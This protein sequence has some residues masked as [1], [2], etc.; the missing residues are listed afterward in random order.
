[1]TANP[2]TTTPS[3]TTL[4]SSST[5]LA[6]ALKEATAQAHTTAEHSRFM[7]RLMAGELDTDH[8]IALTEQLHYLYTALEEAIAR[9]Q[10]DPRIAAVYN[11]ALERSAALAHDL[12]AL[13]GPQ[14][15]SEIADPLPATVNYRLHLT[16]LGTHGQAHLLTAHHYVRYLGDVS[17]GQVIARRLAQTSDISPEALTF[18]QFDLGMGLP[19]FRQAYR[20][21]LNSLPLTD[22]ES[23]SLIEEAIAAF[24]FNTAIFTDLDQVFCD[25][26]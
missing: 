21:G 20:D 11:P 25:S 7:G 10:H 17:G 26:A 19:H 6:A 1:M 8:V 5:P 13:R 12:A 3:P 16:S 23:R 9:V 22:S 18:Y 4:S 24:V 15:E 2:S 14:W